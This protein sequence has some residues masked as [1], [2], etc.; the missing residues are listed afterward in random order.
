MEDEATGQ[1]HR[2]EPAADGAFVIAGLGDGCYTL[3]AGG[4]AVSPYERRGVKASDRP[5]EVRLKRR[6]DPRDVGDHMAELHGELVDAVSGQV[7][8]FTGFQV[9]IR[10]L[11]AGDSTFG[12][13]RLVP[14]GPAQQ[15]ESGEEQNS[16]VEVGLAAGKWGIVAMVPGYAVAIAEFDLR[17]FE[18]KIGVRV[19][20]HRGV[21]VRGRV[22][23]AVGNPVGRAHVFV[24]GVGGLADE[25]LA[26]WRTLREEDRDRGPDP[27]HAMIS[28]WSAAD[29]GF[30][31]GN[32]PANVSLRVVARLAGQGIAVAPLGVPA[33]GNAIDDVQ[34]RLDASLVRR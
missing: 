24:I 10:P 14:R 29:G 15:L 1:T 32:V 12:G 6:A 25:C 8:P 11:R 9:D 17:A 18:M 4:Q 2:G 31:L 21:D 19:P 16:F 28:A 5:I 34:L 33:V 3:H 26:R 7:V 20:L 27:S 22:V 23:D 30:H 13:D